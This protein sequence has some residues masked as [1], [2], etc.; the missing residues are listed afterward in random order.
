MT[1]RDEIAAAA[2]TAT[3]SAAG[4]RRQPLLHDLLITLCGPTVALTG[5]DGD[6]HA[7]D[8]RG[9]TAQGVFHADRRVLSH[10][11]VRVDGARPHAVHATAAGPGRSL[12]TA[13]LRD[14]GDPGADP[15]VRLD[16]HQHVEPGRYAEQLVLR[17]DADAAISAA[18]EV[19]VGGDLAHVE[20]VK[21]GQPALAAL[22]VAVVPGGLQWQDGGIVVELTAPGG[23]L[24]REPLG[25]GAG[26]LT[27]EVELAPYSSVTLGWALRVTDPTAVVAG[28]PTAATWPR[29]VVTADDRRLP[30]LL[31]QALDD[32]HALRLVT[33]E[34]PRDVFL[35]AGAPWFLTLFGR[36]S[37]WAARMLL[38]LGT[39]LAAGTLRTLAGRQGTA[40]DAASAQSPGKILHELRRG[41]FSADAA[42][43][44]PPTYY[45]TIDATPL[46]VCL[47]H[48][49]WRWGLDPE[50]V[51]ALLPALEAALSWIAG[52]AL[53][54]DGFLSY[55]DTSGH[56]LAN[57]G[58]KDSGDSV[59]FADGRLGR[60]P[61]ALAEVQGYAHEAAMAGAQLLDSFG[62]PGA[63]GWRAWASALADRFRSRFWVTDSAG[64]FPA[65]AIAGDGR[66]VDSL[67]SNAGHLLGT[68]LLTPDE[69]ATVAARLTAAD[70]A[71]GFGLRTM[72]TTAGGY[73]PLSYHCGSIW[74][75]DTAVV[76]AGLVRSGHGTAAAELVEG[77]LAASTAYGGR[78]PELWG[79]DPREAVRTPVPYP[80]AC[81]PQ[82]W[83][84][85]AAVSL[86]ASLL[87]LQPDAPHATLRVAPITPSPVGAISVQGLLLAGTPVSV[88]LDAAGTV[89]AVEAGSAMRVTL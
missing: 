79:G 44:L 70:M 52:P 89:V 31:E 26:V 39:E 75:H 74:P 5:T 78:L 22:P 59:R 28:A 71:N 25:A 81:R 46:W 80:A 18:V 15:T 85:A 51:E 24:T 76:V 34:S 60:P 43:V 4:P 20:H 21:A 27:W 86:L 82:A 23:T 29:P 10:L 54:A 73:A 36:D 13:L 83:S 58:W 3:A 2:S 33:R 87:G 11:V 38:P 17:S 61:V 88:D 16:R 9:P 45:G 30:R 40:H 53:D 41:V 84:A 14:L 67:T 57:Q 77:L 35:A 6:V 19:A 12:V 63:D 56:G 37:L 49:A 55:V 48:D 72:S 69:E 47:L 65:I 7:D 50:Q 68:G 62:R 1:L 8:D 32:L 64:P 42:T 66:P